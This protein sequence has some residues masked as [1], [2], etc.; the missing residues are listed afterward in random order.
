MPRF[1]TARQFFLSAGYVVLTVDHGI[2]TTFLPYELTLENSGNRSISLKLRR[3]MVA[4][5]GRVA[6]ESHGGAQPTDTGIFS[7]LL[8][9][10]CLAEKL[11][12]GIVAEYLH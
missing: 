4:R 8:Y 11:L 10:Q 6:V 12:D 3:L 5:A 2:I 9:R 1:R 7:P